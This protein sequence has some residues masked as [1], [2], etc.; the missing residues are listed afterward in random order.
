VGL[1]LAVGALVLASP[2]APRPAQA[3]IL[4]K[5]F[6][7]CFYE[8]PGF[9]ITVVDKETGQPLADVHAL[10]E[11]VQYGF[12][13]RNGPLMVQDA[14]SRRDGVLTFPAWGRIR[15][16]NAGLVI[17]SDPVVTLYKAGYKVLAIF[18]AVPI[19]IEETDQVRGFFQDGQTIAIEPIQWSPAEWVEQLQ[20]AAYPGTKGSTSKEQILQF[21]VP[22]LNRFRRIW[23]ERDKVSP[24][25]KEPGEF[26]WDIEREIKFL[27]E[28]GR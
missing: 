19:G 13:G 26:F 5:W 15:G 28:G 17:N 3:N 20:K 25:H 27:E 1:A 18:N 21:R 14:V 6:G 10:A 16:S 24:R 2:L 4:C 11:W 9:R 8:S 12:H 7:Q 22:Y 23:A